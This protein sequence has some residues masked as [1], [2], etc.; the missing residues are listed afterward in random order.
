LKHK[1]DGKGFDLEEFTQSVLQ[2]LNEAV[3]DKH[4]TGCPLYVTMIAAVCETDMETC[5][6]SEDW[7]NQ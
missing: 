4:F 5:F 6:N 1:S 2:H 3:Y 7:F